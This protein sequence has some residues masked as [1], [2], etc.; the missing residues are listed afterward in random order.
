MEQERHNNTDI[1]ALIG[2]SH[3]MLGHAEA[4]DWEAVIR[5]ED[6]R[7]QLIHQFFSS[8]SNMADVQGLSAAIQELLQIN[9]ELERLVTVAREK[10]RSEVSTIATGRKAVNAYADNAA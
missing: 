2:H 8:P 1:A 4:G 10:A 3:V 7:R 9:D 5:D 6:K